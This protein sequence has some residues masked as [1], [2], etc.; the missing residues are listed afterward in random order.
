M[1]R[2]LFIM[3]LIT[4]ATIAFS[5]YGQDESKVV[6]L[7]S[8]CPNFA[9]VDQNPFVTFAAALRKDKTS[10]K[11]RVSWYGYLGSGWQRGTM[12]YDR[13]ARSL[14]YFDTGGSGEKGEYFYLKHYMFTGIKDGTFFNLVRSYNN[15]KHITELLPQTF[16]DVLSKRGHRKYKIADFSRGS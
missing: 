9:Y 11:F 2:K 13:K 16:L 12:L 6:Q 3:M 1:K 5:A 4:E 7:G 8:N 15:Q 14:K 10:P